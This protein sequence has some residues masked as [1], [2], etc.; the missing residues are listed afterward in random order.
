MSRN[1][2]KYCRETFQRDLQSIFW[3]N[4]LKQ[5]NVN[6]GCSA[7][8]EPSLNVL[9]KHARIV[10]RNVRGRDLP[11]LNN[12][13]KK[14]VHEQDYHFRKVIQPGGENFWSTYR[15]KSTRVTYMIRQEKAR[16]HKNMTHESQSATQSVW[17]AIKECLPNKK[18]CE[19]RPKSL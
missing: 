16:Y 14:A 17:K 3:E 7:F 19:Q 12:A 5:T 13:I 15:R 4:T 2:S 18:P 6:D 9:N 1:F 11:W 8:K 10:E